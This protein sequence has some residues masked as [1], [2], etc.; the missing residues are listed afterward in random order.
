MERIKLIKE[1][2]RECH[3]WFWRTFDVLLLTY[4][5]GDI[6]APVQIRDYK[7]EWHEKYLKATKKAVRKHYEDC[8]SGNYMKDEEELELENLFKPTEETPN[9]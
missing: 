3:D 4:K 7:K 6:T 9:E 2:V 1:E 5:I 8:K